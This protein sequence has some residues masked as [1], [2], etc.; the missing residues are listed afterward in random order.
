MCREGF[1]FSYNGLWCKGLQC[2]YKIDISARDSILVLH[3]ERCHPQIVFSPL[4]AFV[5]HSM[6]HFLWWTHSMFYIKYRIIFHILIPSL[7]SLHTHPFFF[8]LWNFF[9]RMTGHKNDMRNFFLSD[10]CEHMVP[11]IILLLFSG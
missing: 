1:N 2:F 11:I 4:F 9:F 3:W 8:L 5:I 6:F 7:R 10:V